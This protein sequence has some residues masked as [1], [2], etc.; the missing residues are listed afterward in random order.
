MLLDRGAGASYKERQGNTLFSM[1]LELL[2]QWEVGGVQLLSHAQYHQRSTD[3][4]PGR[5]R[6]FTGF[7]ALFLHNSKDASRVVCVSIWWRGR[8]WKLTLH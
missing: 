7:V 8:S 3:F 2:C 6:D 5:H 4:P 1:A